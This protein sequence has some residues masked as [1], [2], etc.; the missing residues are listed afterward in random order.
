MDKKH[1]K[2]LI[3]HHMR[4]DPAQENFPP[5]PPKTFLLASA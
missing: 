1:N 5:N 4:D 3:S 2:I